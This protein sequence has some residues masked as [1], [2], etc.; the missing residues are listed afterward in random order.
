MRSRMPPCRYS[1]R[2]EEGVLWC[3][4]AS[5]VDRG[6]SLTAMKRRKCLAEPSLRQGPLGHDVNL[7]APDLKVLV[8]SISSSQLQVEH[9]KHERS[10]LHLRLR[11]VHTR[12]IFPY[13][14]TYHVHPSAMSNACNSTGACVQSNH[15]TRSTVLCLSDSSSFLRRSG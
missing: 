2:K 15:A 6:P 1:R 4:V 14:F 5:E 3:C 10:S 9:C 8:L 12:L 11:R 7:F 13:G